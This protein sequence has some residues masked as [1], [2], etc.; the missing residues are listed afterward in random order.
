MIKVFSIKYIVPDAL[1]TI[2]NP[3][4]EEEVFDESDF[5]MKKIRKIIIKPKKE[6]PGQAEQEGQAE[7]SSSM[8]A[9]TG[10][11]DIDNLD[12]NSLHQ[13]TK[14][15]VKPTTETKLE[16]KH[17]ADKPSEQNKVQEEQQDTDTSSSSSDSNQ[18][19]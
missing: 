10:K 12:M 6:L 15:A 3:D 11:L 16:E 2:T 19:E 13:N 1:S 5:S 9:A 8:K 4:T 14:L 18:E 7:P 17:E